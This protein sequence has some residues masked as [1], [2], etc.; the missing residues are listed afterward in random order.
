MKSLRPTL[1]LGICLSVACSESA[2]QPASGAPQA[3]AAAAPMEVFVVPVV[4]ETVPVRTE[5]PGRISARRVAEIR[6]R[7]PGILLERKFEEGS[8][9]KEGQILF[10]IDAAPLRAK[11]DRAKAALKRAEANLAQITTTTKR[12][13]SLIGAKA[14]SQ[15]ELDDAEAQK[16][17]REAEVIEAEAALRSA[18]LD[19]GYAS[20]RAP[21]SGRIGKALVTEGTLVGQN[22][23]T[24]LAVIQQLDPVYFDFEQSS[25]ELLALRRKLAAGQLEQTEGGAQ[26]TLLLD[27]GSE[28]EHRGKLLFSDVTVDERTGMVTLRADVPNPEGTLLPGMFAR[29]RIDQA[30]TRDALTIPQRTVALGPNGS[31]SVLVVDQEGKVE[32]REIVLDRAVGDRWVVASGLT[33]GMKVIIEGRQ[34]A[35]PGAPVIAVDWKD[36]NKAASGS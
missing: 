19:L 3:A 5:L 1:L 32:R 8:D 31:A 20:V 23:A 29:A 14:V 34:K 25:A 15:Q 7:V 30:V 22:E 12:Y 35:R 26:L 2:A 17:Q 9:V 24:R 13:A 18:A 33:D 28:Y 4:R 10:Q 36:E 6:A 27:D 11:H 21:I 16:L